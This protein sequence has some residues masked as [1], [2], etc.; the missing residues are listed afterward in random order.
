MIVLDAGVISEIFQPTSEP[1]VLDW[2]AT[3]TGYVAITSVTLAELLAGVR[4][5]PDGR[6]RDDLTG[7]IDA[8]LADRGRT[9][10]RRQ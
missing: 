10:P 4:R 3:L 8:A 1:R 9:H 7:R 5:L 2:I 6:R